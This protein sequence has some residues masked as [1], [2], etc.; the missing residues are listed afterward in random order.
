MK[1]LGLL[2]RHF[3]YPKASPGVRA[4]IRWWFSQSIVYR[5]QQPLWG[6]IFGG[7]GTPPGKFAKTEVAK[8]ARPFDGRSCANCQRWYLHNATGTGICS[9]VDGTW[10][11]E[12]W[13]EFWIEPMSRDRYVR[14]QTGR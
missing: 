8:T 14:Y 4:F 5:K 11:A 7:G 1:L 9:W 13:C 6:A 10:Q 3:P 12:E 2:P